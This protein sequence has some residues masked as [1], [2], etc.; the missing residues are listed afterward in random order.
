MKTNHTPGP[1]KI[2]DSHVQSAITAGKKHVAMVGYYISTDDNE[3]ITPKEHK[4][5]AKLIASAPDLL[6]ENAALNSE[7]RRFQDDV[8]DLILSRLESV[9]IHA[10]IDGSGSDG[11][12]SELTLSEI[13]QGF[14]HLIEALY[15]K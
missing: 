11:G 5:N 4:A 12:W 7:I 9:G 3:T 8:R 10:D 13:S 6:L 1:W 2:D 15:E 14:N